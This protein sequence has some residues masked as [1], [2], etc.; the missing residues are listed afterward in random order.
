LPQES[1]EMEVDYC[2]LSE[3]PNEED[4]FWLEMAVDRRGGLIMMHNILDQSPSVEDIVHLLA[5]AMGC[6]HT[7]VC[8]RPETIF[9]RDNP[10]WEGLFAGEPQP[11]VASSKAVKPVS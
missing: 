4:G 2:S 3:I 1:I 7:G 9:L 5:S 6:P 8:C 10:E 11:V